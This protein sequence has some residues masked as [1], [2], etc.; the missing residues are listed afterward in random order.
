[1]DWRFPAQDLGGRRQF[2]LLWWQ[3]LGRISAEEQA[4]IF[5]Y[6]PEVLS[7]L[8]ITHVLKHKRRIGKR[9]C[10]Y[11]ISMKQDASQALGMGCFPG[12]A[13][14]FLQNLAH[15]WHTELPRTSA[16]LRFSTDSQ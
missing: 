13:L 16:K 7:A 9:L 5:L 12:P 2:H 3:A 6:V 8:K 10:D 11:A 14:L 4:N 1:M 15:N